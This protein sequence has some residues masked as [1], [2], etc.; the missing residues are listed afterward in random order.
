MSHTKE[1]RGIIV[2][3]QIL[4]ARGFPSPLCPYTS[5]VVHGHSETCTV[6]TPCFKIGCVSRYIIQFRNLSRRRF[7]WSSSSWVSNKQRCLSQLFVDQYASCTN[8]Q[9]DFQHENFQHTYQP[10]YWITALLNTH[11]ACRHLWHVTYES[12][13]THARVKSHTQHTDSCGG[14]HGQLWI[15]TE[16]RIFATRLI[17]IRGISLS[18]LYT[19]F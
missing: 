13:H 16:V 19:Q 1:F 9:I 18:Y 3:I 7:Y 4:C 14:R 11:F 15:L 8:S 12:H 10:L 2:W 6:R 5:A 17:H